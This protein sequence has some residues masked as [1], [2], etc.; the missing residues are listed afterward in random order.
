MQIPKNIECPLNLEVFDISFSIESFSP[1]AQNNGTT[2]FRKH[3]PK[4]QHFSFSMFRD[5]YRYT[6]QRLC[7][8]RKTQISI[9]LIIYF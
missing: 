7:I 3:V 9:Q 6:Q 1:A 4:M 2:R 5:V 8:E